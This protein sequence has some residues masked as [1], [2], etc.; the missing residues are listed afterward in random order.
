MLSHWL[1]QLRGEH[2]A[3]AQDVADGR[4]FFWIGS[5]ISR[6]QAPDLVELIRQ[7]LLFLRDRAWSG[8]DD[9]ADHE[10]A[11]RRILASHLPH[12][13]TEYN[14]R[15]ESWV[16]GDLEST[17]NSYSQIL[18]TWVDRKATSNYLLMEAASV[19]SRYGDPSIEPGLD[20]QLLAIL[21]AEGV[22]PEMASGNWDGLI[23]RAVRKFT[24]NPKRLAVHV[25]A[26]DTRDTANVSW[27]AKFHGC[28]VKA[29]ENPAEYGAAIIATT[30]QISAWS[31]APEFAHLRDPL[32]QKV[33]QFRSVVLGLS[34]QDSDLLNIFTSAASTHP[35]TWEADHPAYVFAEPR[36]LDAQETVLAN[37][38][39]EYGANRPE[40]L[41]R[42]AFG[43]YSEA[44][45]GALVIY[46]VVEKLKAALRRNDSLS[47]LIIHDLEIGVDALEELVT[48]L[49]RAEV[50]RLVQI[51][52]L[53]FSRLVEQFYGSQHFRFDGSYTPLL[54]GPMS[55][56]EQDP[57]VTIT[58]A[59]RFALMIGLF[60]RGRFSARWRLRIR[61]VDNY[62][63]LEVRRNSSAPVLVALASDEASVD[64]VLQLPS[65]ASGAAE[66]AIVHASSPRPNSSRASASRLGAL[67]GA[68]TR[69]EV[70]LDDVISNARSTE[71]ALDNLFAGGAA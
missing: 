9:S 10:D 38:Y 2:E 25:L 19:P 49:T 66:M 39:S 54:D 61:E 62:S 29:L 15:G 16:P 48:T 52:T 28:A 60:G 65:W 18:G 56:V 58:G 42:S 22:L 1:A 67:R 55:K 57:V 33:Q 7:T 64:A 20:H 32:V 53:G 51:L 71:D 70:W 27:L 40:I 26:K 11:L 8:V 13:L 50:G 46:V 37:S 23:E 36:L 4:R 44:L 59:N 5:G 30:G 41:K 6:K 35:W 31:V 43:E 68:D 34:V 69:R 12:E 47:S 14:D 17:R 3:L 45:L 63:F 21:I 24:G